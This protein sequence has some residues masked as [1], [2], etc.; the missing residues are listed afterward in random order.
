M[1]GGKSAGRTWAII[2]YVAIFGR[3]KLATDKCQVVM[4]NEKLL[5]IYYLRVSAA[6]IKGQNN[7]FKD[8]LPDSLLISFIHI[9]E[10]S[11]YSFINIYSTL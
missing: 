10:Y 7:F 3:L 1:T 9:H 5:K 11:Y 6:L 8:I 4:R 2:W